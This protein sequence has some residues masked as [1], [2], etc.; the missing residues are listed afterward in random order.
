MRN[1]NSEQQKT[2][3][4]SF[5][6]SLLSPKTPNSNSSTSTNIL[7]R[8]PR[9]N[10]KLTSSV[11]SSSQPRTSSSAAIT[12]SSLKSEWWLY[13]T[14]E[15]KGLA[16]AGLAST[17]KLGVRILCS[18]PIAKRHTATILETT[19]GVTITLSGS[20]DR[21]RTRQ[22]GFSLE[23]CNHFLIGFPYYWENPA[24]YNGEALADRTIPTEDPNNLAGSVMPSVCSSDHHIP[25]S[26]D[27]ILVTEMRDILMS[28]CRNPKRCSLI[29][30]ISEDLQ[31]KLCENASS[32]SSEL[33]ICTPAAT[34]SELKSRQIEENNII[35]TTDKREVVEDSFSHMVLTRGRSRLNFLANKQKDALP[36]LKNDN[37][38][39][40]SRRDFSCSRVNNGSQVKEI[41]DICTIRRSNR[42][43]RLKFS[44]L[45]ERY[46][47]SLPP[48]KNVYSK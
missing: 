36:P 34:P 30:G 24:Q 21:S 16:V 6:F 44:T 7:G 37:S 33:V 13:K 4:S 45:T 18:A 2:K 20:I 35:N 22:N 27:D 10:F 12:P 41:P 1:I 48:Q 47:G 25:N 14:N 40:Q 17:Q 43:K 5:G 11:T 9:W 42:A 19:D 3:A 32:K 38:G 8:R 26:L 28:P 29:D 23:V 31:S 15:D 46:L 39:V